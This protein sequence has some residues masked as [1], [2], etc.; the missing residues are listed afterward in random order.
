MAGMPPIR[1][2]PYSVLFRTLSHTVTLDRPPYKPVIN[3]TYRTVN[4]IVGQR[5]KR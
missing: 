3:D 1:H 2:L 5:E 4:H